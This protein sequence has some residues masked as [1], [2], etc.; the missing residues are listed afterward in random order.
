MS[1]TRRRWHCALA[2]LLACSATT[3]R[4]TNVAPELL[5][6]HARIFTLNDSAPWASA[7]AINHGR[8]T[9]V[10]DDAAALALKGPRTRV[11]DLRGRLLTPGFIDSHVHFVDGGRYLRNVPLRDATTFKEVAARV[12]HYSAAHEGAGWIQGEGFSY[13]YP[14]LPR[15]EFHKEL[16]DAVSGNRPVFLSSGMAHA[17]WVNSA[18]LRIAGIDARTRDPAGG[19]IVRG[20]GGEPTGWLKEE[21]AV[22]LVQRH[23]PKPM[24]ADNRAALLAAI[25]EA[26]RLGI[27]RV[28]SAGDDFEM[29]PVLAGLQR[30][31]L[32]TLRIS[33]A[34]W[35]NPPGLDPQ[36][37]FKLETARRRYHGDHLTCCVAKFIMDGVIESHTAYLPGGY[38]DRPDQ[39]GMHFFERGPYQAAVKTLNA[40]G[41]QIYTHAIGDGAIRLALDA[42]A[43][44][45]A[46]LP[47]GAA[48]RNR[49]EHAEAPDAA[50]I[51][52]FGSLDVIASM[53]PLM[54]YPRDEWKG[55][56]GLWERYAGAKFLPTAFALRSLLDARAT[57]AFGTD[58]PIVQ[59]N[60]LLGMRNAVLRQSLDGQPAAGYLP[61]QRISIPEALRAYTLAGAYASHVERDEGS[62]EVGKRADLVLLSQNF[63][64]TSL[65]NAARITVLMTFIDGKPVFIDKPQPS[66]YISAPRR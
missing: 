15:G 49:I 23:L 2:L 31:G 64:E 60:P 28:D 8:I 38:A 13:G 42:Y 37:L 55:M 50:D 33:I 43:A 58:W 14:D 56:E 62:I 9:L 18:A 21:A 11:I 65:E 10:G 48:P 61:A 34:D 44:S 40:H 25:H 24:A 27:T 54:I 30:A 41:F 59:L 32:L 63:V 29:L 26:N 39:Q 53:Q 57:L 17:A 3:A 45:Q 4:S 47:P 12:T 1:K 46:A 20:E 52:R 16:L 66:A 5:L 6:V 35:I 36:E 51:A 7:I 19:E 22:A